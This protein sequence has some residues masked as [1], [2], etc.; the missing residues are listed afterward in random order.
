MFAKN[1]LE[2]QTGIKQPKWA[3]AAEWGCWTMFVIL[4]A[5]VG[6]TLLP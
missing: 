2:R 5:Y 4:S 3:I 1:K 6:Y